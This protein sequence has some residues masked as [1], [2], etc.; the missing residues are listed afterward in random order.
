MK[1]STLVSVGPNAEWSVDGHD[2]LRVMAVDIYGIRDVHTGRHQHYVVLPS[3]RFAEVIGV[4]QLQCVKK[5]G[6][7]ST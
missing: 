1:R 4:V 3:N 7:K 5:V 2:K 6:G